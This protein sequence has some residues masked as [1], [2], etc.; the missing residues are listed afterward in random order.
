MDRLIQESTQSVGLAAEVMAEVVRIS[1]L[2]VEPGERLT[3]HPTMAVKTVR[4]VAERR[5]LPLAVL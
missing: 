4:P 3:M 2:L 1:T 5:Y